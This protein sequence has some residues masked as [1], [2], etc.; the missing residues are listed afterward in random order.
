MTLLINAN[1]DFDFV[2]GIIKTP[3]LFYFRSVKFHFVEETHM[4]LVA[5]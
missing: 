2:N 5:F 4:M 1:K 3:S